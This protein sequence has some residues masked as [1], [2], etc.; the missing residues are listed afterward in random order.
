MRDGVELNAVVHVR[1][2]MYAF[3]LHKHED[4]HCLFGTLR[5]LCLTSNSTINEQKH[6]ST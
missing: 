1:R 3:G 4:D 2:V 6:R 5:K